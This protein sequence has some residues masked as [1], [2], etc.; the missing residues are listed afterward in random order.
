MWERKHKVEEARF[1]E[2]HVRN[3]RN[4]ETIFCFPIA[5]PS[6]RS[7]VPFLAF[8]SVSVVGLRS[9]CVYLMASFLF[10]PSC[11][12]C[13]ETTSIVDR[14]SGSSL[15]E[16]EPSSIARKKERLLDRTLRL[17]RDCIPFPTRTRVEL[18]RTCSYV[19][20]DASWACMVS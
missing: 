3:V 5:R 7:F 13:G 19:I 11:A 4:Q 15:D 1:H 14:K 20:W 18:S 9:T 17:T 16:I 6:I 2:A 8:C 10:R 12:T